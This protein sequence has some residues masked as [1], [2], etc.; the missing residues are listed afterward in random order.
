[1]NRQKGHRKEVQR[2]AGI[3]NRTQTDVT[4]RAP[5]FIG[6]AIV[7][8]VLVLM[9]RVVPAATETNPPLVVDAKTLENS[10]PSLMAAQREQAIYI[11]RNDP[12]TRNLTSGRTYQITKPVVWTKSDG[13]IV[14]AAVR[15]IFSRPSTL[16]GRWL[17]I[18]Y[19][20]SENTNPPYLSVAYRARRAY[21]TSLT[22]LVD[23]KR[24]QV[25][26]IQPD[27]LSRLVGRPHWVRQPG[28]P[29]CR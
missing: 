4:N 17:A 2:Q 29:L 5:V 27:G 10:V 18:D 14:G 20:C 13:E 16:A 15:L 26:S 9:I 7:V 8:L 28:V 11:I 19:D 23:L 1:M 24:Q 21:V 12:T 3:T 25:V 22:L 6:G